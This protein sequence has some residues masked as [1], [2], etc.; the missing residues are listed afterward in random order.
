MAG[1]ISNKTTIAIKVS[2]SFVTIAGVT[3][4]N[5]LMGGSAATIDV[6]DLA[7][8]AKEKLMGIPDSGSVS[9]AMNYIKGDAGQAA[10]L[11]AYQS[12]EM[13]DFEVTLPSGDKYDFSAF[14]SKHGLIYSVDKQI[15]IDAALEVTGVVTAVAGA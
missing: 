5:G 15:T 11:A 1:T 6:S 10:L 2:T 12:A 13:S 8:D 4:I 7:S 3:G 9:V 14:V